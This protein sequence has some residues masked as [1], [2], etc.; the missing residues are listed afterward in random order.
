VEA[1]VGPA[2]LAGIGDTVPAAR[3]GWD[4]P[5]AVPAAA[6]DTAEFERF[7]REHHRTVHRF[8]LH[9]V[10]DAAQADDVAS[11]VLVKV[12]MAWRGGR[13]QHANAY[14]R[15]AVVNHVNSWLRR[16]QVERRWLQR[17]PPP[18]EEDLTGPAADR[19]AD[20]ELLTTALMRLTV[21]QRAVVV[22]RYYDDLSEQET[23]DALGISVGT[24]K[25]QTHRAVARLR[26][27]LGPHALEGG[28][29]S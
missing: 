4:G 12:F 13:V 16:R 29:A 7:F 23:A 15:R 25:S 11:E 19:M 18:V 21:R 20:A 2:V 9:L 6:R 22:L 5:V 17:Q 26:D 27:L 10:G 14:L 1:T 8:A 3:S 28:G 24:V